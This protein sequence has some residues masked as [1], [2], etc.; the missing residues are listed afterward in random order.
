MRPRASTWPSRKRR[1]L[2]P[3]PIAGGIYFY[4]KNAE[5]VSTGSQTLYIPY[6]G[7]AIVV[8]VLAAVFYFA[9]VPDIK[10]EDDY[11]LDDDRA[12]AE[13]SKVRRGRLTAGWSTCSCGPTRPVL[14][15]ICG[16]ILWLIL[17]AC[18]VG[19]YLVGIASLL[20]HP[21]SITITEANSLMVVICAIAGLLVAALALLLIPLAKRISHHSICS[22]PHFSGATMAQF[23]YVAAQAGIFSFLI[24]Y[25]TAEVP[26]IPSSWLTDTL[27]SWF[28]AKNGVLHFS[29]TGAAIWRRW[30][31]CAF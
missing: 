1:G 16:M 13:V 30:A 20:P 27:A 5:G 8:T 12:A 14:T 23:F 11:H 31:S 10:S 6:V 19:P 28:E 18:G 22:H 4:S 29:D 7:I 21:A 2:D 24:N 26:P 15:C 3:G 17:S 9:N 25:M